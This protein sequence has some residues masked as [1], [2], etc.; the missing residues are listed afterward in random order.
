VIRE[1]DKH[2]VAYLHLIEAKGSEM[3]LTDELHEDAV[4]NAALF[5]EMFH[6][7]FLSAAAYTPESAALAIEKK[8]ADAIAFAR[9]T[10]GEQH[11]W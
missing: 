7:S 3:G 1:I 2:R 10:I 5:R 6:G 11:K 4:N 9:L 8:H